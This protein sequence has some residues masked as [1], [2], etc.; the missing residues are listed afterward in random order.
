MK[1][2]KTVVE[3]SVARDMANKNLYE[4]EK[5]KMITHI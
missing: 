5:R 3:G 1:N 2:E 4:N